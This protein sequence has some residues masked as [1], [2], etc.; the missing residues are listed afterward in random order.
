MAKKLY[1]VKLCNRCIRRNICNLKNDPKTLIEK[2][3]EFKVKSRPPFTVNVYSFCKHFMPEQ[4]NTE[5][6]VSPK[7]GAMLTTPF[8]TIPA[9]LEARKRIVIEENE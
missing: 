8:N 4:D 3:I 7:G 5:M 1:G 2:P 9:D 6:M